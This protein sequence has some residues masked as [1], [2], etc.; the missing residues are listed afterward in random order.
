M[1]VAGCVL[2]ASQ[3]LICCM[4][5]IGCRLQSFPHQSDANT[6]NVAQQQASFSDTVPGRCG[7][8]AASIIEKPWYAHC[9][10]SMQTTVTR[11]SHSAMMMFQMSL[12]GAQF[13]ADV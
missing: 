8:S 3:S 11:N 12:K 4:S 10:H 9:S 2:A 6:L 7:A 13:D 1:W 5:A